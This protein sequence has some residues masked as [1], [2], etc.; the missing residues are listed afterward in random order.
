LAPDSPPPSAPQPRKPRLLILEFWG[1]GDLIFATTVLPA[2]LRRYEVTIVGKEHARTLL[3]PTFHNLEYLSYNAPW[4]AFKQKYQLSRWN[5]RE[6]FDLLRRLRTTCFDVAISVRE[7]PRDHLLMRLIGARARVGFPRKGS[8]LLLT[9]SLRNIPG[10]AHRVE[11]WRALGEALALPDMRQ[12]KPH[13]AHDRYRSSRVNDIFES[14]RSPTI[15]LHAGARLA[16]RRW[17]EEHFI[18]VINQL[19]R[20]YAF[21]LIIIPDPDGYGS[22]L[23]SLADTFV[24]ELTLTELVDLLGRV[25]LLVCNDSGPA[26][27]AAACGRPVISIFGPTDP[28][29]FHPWENKERVVIRDI[30]PWRPCFDYCKFSE[31]HCLTKLSSETAWSDIQRHIETLLVTGVLPRA[32]RPSQSPVSTSS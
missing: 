24:P 21:H 20:A 30:C 6:L 22:A 23:S 19:R 16:T 10:K 13:L 18:Q 32:L 27:I 4:T 29:W 9:Q 2:A 17:P 15:C 5:W 12:A 14:I 8:G 11:R 28:D 3:Q 7:D 25:D 31:P 1:L 26:H